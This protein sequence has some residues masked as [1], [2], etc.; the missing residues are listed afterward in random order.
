MFGNVIEDQL[1]GLENL[2]RIFINRVSR[3]RNP[4]TR[5]A[6]SR[7]V[8]APGSCNDQGNGDYKDGNKESPEI[9]GCFPA[10]S[11]RT[12]RAVHRSTPAVADGSKRDG[13]L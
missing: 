3:M 5:I 1:V 10:A 12:E 4:T 6:K 8:I 7:I 2:E 11:G 9:A 13:S